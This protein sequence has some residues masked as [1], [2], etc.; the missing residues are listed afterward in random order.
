MLGQNTTMYLCFIAGEK[1]YKKRFSFE[2]ESQSGV[3]LFLYKG[4]GIVGGGDKGRRTA[5]CHFVQPRVTGSTNA[6]R[7]QNLRW[8]KCFV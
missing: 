3:S 7:G 4:P 5:A 8:N 6:F 2:S 1:N